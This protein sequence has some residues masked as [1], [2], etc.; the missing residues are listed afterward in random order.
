M[1]R[2]PIPINNIGKIFTRQVA[3][4]KYVARC[5]FRQSDGKT[6]QVERRAKSKTAAQRALLAEVDERRGKRIE[7]IYSHHRTTVLMDLYLDRLAGRVARGAVAA[8]SADRYRYALSLARPLIGELRINEL[9]LGR[10]EAMFDQLA[11]RGYATNTRRGVRAVLS[12]VLTIAQRQG[13]ISTNLI[14]DVPPISDRRRSDAGPRALT[15]E[16]RRQLFAWLAGDETEA[17]RLARQRSMPELI[18]LMIGTGVRLGEALALCWEN[19]DLEGQPFETGAGMILM[20]SIRITGNVVRVP[21]L[22]K[23]VHPGKTARSLR[24]VP[25]P[26]TV[27]EMLRARRPDDPDPTE[28]VFPANGRRGRGLTW[29]E[30]T[31][32]ALHIREIRAELGWPWLTSHVFRKTAATIVHEAGVSD[33]SLGEH[34][35]HTDRSSLLNVYLGSP[36]LDPR[37]INALDAALR[38]T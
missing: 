4:T 25:I 24:T 37:L 7:M 23:V 12:Q 28:P 3:P 31:D 36:D 30:P 17:Q 13:A 26:R 14:R 20:P 29:R 1:A 11:A 33:L 18:L 16:Q 21:S 6:I 8:T 34:I 22:G 32:V 35:G 2:P 19:V 10:L 27:A 38:D 5:R 15:A 9:T